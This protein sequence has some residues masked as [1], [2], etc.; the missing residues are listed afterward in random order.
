[1]GII[2]EGTNLEFGLWQC[3]VGDEK[4]KGAADRGNSDDN[5]WDVKRFLGF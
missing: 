3:V 4:G 1:M 2:S 5:W